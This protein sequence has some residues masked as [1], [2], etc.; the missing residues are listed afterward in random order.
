MKICQLPLSEIPGILNGTLYNSEYNFRNKVFFLWIGFWLSR[1][2]FLQRVRFFGTNQAMLKIDQNLPARSRKR[3]EAPIPRVRKGLPG[4]G[5]ERAPSNDAV[6]A[7]DHQA[8]PAAEIQ[9]Y[10]L[11][12]RTPKRL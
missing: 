10:N 6:S 7:L 9:H 4:F 2:Q 3:G 12:T 8:T 1:H 11:K 5:I